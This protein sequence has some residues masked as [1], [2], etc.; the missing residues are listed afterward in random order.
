MVYKLST[1]TATPNLLQVIVIHVYALCYV[2]IS[3]I[4]VVAAANVVVFVVVAVSSAQKNCTLVQ[5]S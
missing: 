4:V 5:T 1:S 3:I 2:I